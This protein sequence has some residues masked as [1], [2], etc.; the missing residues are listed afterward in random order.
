MF[1]IILFQDSSIMC[2]RFFRRFE[3]GGFPELGQR[4]KNSCSCDKYYRSY[5]PLREWRISENVTAFDSQKKD[6][7]CHIASEVKLHIQ[8]MNNVEANACRNKKAEREAFID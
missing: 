6:R 5:R 1:G 3:F 8:P 7:A 2:D 4:S